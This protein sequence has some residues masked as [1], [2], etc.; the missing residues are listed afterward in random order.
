MTYALA[1][2][3]PADGSEPTEPNEV[4][5]SGVTAPPSR[6]YPS[7][8]IPM[9]QTAPVCETVCFGYSTLGVQIYNIETFVETTESYIGAALAAFEVWARVHPGAEPVLVLSQTSN[10]DNGDYPCVYADR[11]PCNLAADEITWFIMDV[12]AFYSVFFKVRTMYEGDMPISI[13]TMLKHG[14][15]GSHTSPNAQV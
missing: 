14:I 10:F 11:S 5:L 2:V 9:G 13:S 6:H 1:D 15:G 3:Q 8:V 12:S 7:V 4:F